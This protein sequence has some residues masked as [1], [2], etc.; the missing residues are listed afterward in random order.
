MV[1][2]GERGTQFPMHLWAP[3]VG[4]GGPSHGPPPTSTWTSPPTA[5]ICVDVTTDHP[6]HVDV[7]FATDRRL[8]L[9]GHHAV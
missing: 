4:P 7:D 6:T 9:R 8:R 2:H 5:A 3:R 1:W